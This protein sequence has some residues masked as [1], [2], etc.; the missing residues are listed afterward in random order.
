MA[1]A[2]DTTYF[3]YGR[4]STIDKLSQI[5]EDG[6]NLE[7]ILKRL[8][9]AADGHAD[10]TVYFVEARVDH[11]VIEC[12]TAWSE[13]QGFI[14]AMYRAFRH[15][16][17]FRI[18]WRCEESGCDYFV[19]NVKGAL[20]GEYL[21]DVFHGTEYHDTF[22]ECKGYVRDTFEWYKIGTPDWSTFEEMKQWL[23]MYA[24]ENDEI[25]FVHR[26]EIVDSPSKLDILKLRQVSEDELYEWFKT[27]SYETIYKMFGIKKKEP[28]TELEFQEYC[29]IINSRWRRL[30]VEDKLEM[31]TAYSN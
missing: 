30:S 25:T 23:D 19:S 13:Q 26:F 14:K 9:Q 21:S 5:V 7:D 22:E 15:D 24:E 6:I 31:Y 3:V 18:D 11:I 29:D 20:Y 16:N 28:M 17:S 8:G 2:A 4:K 27:R 10:G 1:N 12:E